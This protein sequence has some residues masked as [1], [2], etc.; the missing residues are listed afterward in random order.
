MYFLDTSAVLEVIYGTEK[1]KQIRILTQG[2]PIS[3]SA[4]TIHE[5]LVGLK[6]NEVTLINNFLTEV[7]VTAFDKDSAIKS[8]EIERT[9][10]KKG[11]LINKIDI[12]IAG[13][14]LI[15]KYDLVTCD[16]DFSALSNLKLH[17]Y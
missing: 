3:V 16:T 9:L 2:S 15:H 8:A 1:G 14:C 13:T 5:L 10:K 12:L 4:L 6:E 7:T 17:L 11:K